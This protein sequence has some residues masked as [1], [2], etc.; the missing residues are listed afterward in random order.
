V[1]FFEFCWNCLGT[2]GCGCGFV[3]CLLVDIVSVS[4]YGSGGFVCCC[5]VWILRVGDLCYPVYFALW[6]FVGFCRVLV[7]F[8]VLVCIGW[9]G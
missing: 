1:W 8:F 4:W 9:S 6:W 2:V 3:F 7:V 5:A